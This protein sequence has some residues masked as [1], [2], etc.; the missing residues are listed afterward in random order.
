M[1]SSTM[2]A[3]HRRQLGYYPV[4][5]CGGNIA[6]HTEDDT[7]EIADREHL[8][9]DI[10]LYATAVLRTVNAP[11]PPFDFRRTIESMHASLA[12]YQEL[13]GDRF[14]FGPA[15]AEGDRL[16]AALESFYRRIAR[17]TGIA[18]GDDRAR[19]ATRQ[20]MEL[21]RLLIPVNY[22]REGP[23]RQDPAE[24]IPA[25]P[26]LAAARI[27]GES[28]PGSHQDHAAQI[29]LQRGMNRLVYALRRAHDVVAGAALGGP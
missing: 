13:A 12:A 4:G 18:V 17:L 3:E 21:A 14:D 27:L 22:A 29:S 25:L 20:I 24:N 11:V 1:L 28:E 16:Q 6:W 8:L 10:R 9:R 15:A 19:A 7:L 23:F 26:D 5:G 2:T